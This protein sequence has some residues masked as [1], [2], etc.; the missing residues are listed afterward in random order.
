MPKPVANNNFPLAAQTSVEICAAN[1][2]SAYLIF[3]ALIVRPFC[4]KVNPAIF[5]AE[6]F[7]NETVPLMAGTVNRLSETGSDKGALL[8]NGRNAVNAFEFS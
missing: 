1:G 6:S 3:L 4:N 2:F 8:K 5:P 7:S